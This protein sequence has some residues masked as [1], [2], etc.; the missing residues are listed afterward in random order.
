M[1][2][3]I[4]LLSCGAV[5]LTDKANK[6]VRSRLRKLGARLLETTGATETWTMGCGS[7]RRR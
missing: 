5:V 3:K 2:K 7:G 6:S 4:R 1:A